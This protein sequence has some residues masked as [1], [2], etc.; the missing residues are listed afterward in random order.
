M[1]SMPGAVS[2]SASGERVEG[3]SVRNLVA[4][5]GRGSVVGIFA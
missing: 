2:R 4:G 5:S 3:G 1:T